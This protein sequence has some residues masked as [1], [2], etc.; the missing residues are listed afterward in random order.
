MYLLDSAI[1]KK[2]VSRTM[3]IIGHNINVMNGQGVIL[4]SGDPKRMGSVHEGALLAIAQ[5]RNVELS[6]EVA[7]GLHGVKPGI[8]LPLHYQGQII[9]VIG[10][11]GDPAELTHY[12]ELLKMTAE[13]I[14]EQANQQD[15]LQWENR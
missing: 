14:V 9:G 10:I 4:G 12:G 13:M 5:N 1:A 15:K 11:T 3:K 7:S 2:I 8:N 6:E